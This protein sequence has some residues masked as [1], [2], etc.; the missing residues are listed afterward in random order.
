MVEK[1]CPSA[2]LS[3]IFLQ[4]EDAEP[5]LYA[6]YF[7]IFQSRALEEYANFV[8]SSR[9]SPEPTNLQTLSNLH[10]QAPGIAQ[11]RP[12]DSQAQ[13]CEALG[14]QKH[15]TNDPLAKQIQPGVTQNSRKWIFDMLVP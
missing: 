13:P 10:V 15:F 1:F 2:A 7:V 3:E 8:E 14:L 11:G 5:A 4:G 9:G 6:K 12:S